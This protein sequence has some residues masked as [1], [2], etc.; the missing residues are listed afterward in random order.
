MLKIFKCFEMI[1]ENASVY[2]YSVNKLEQK[3]QIVKFNL[4]T[5]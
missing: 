2:L 4:S 5:I 1:L 3:R